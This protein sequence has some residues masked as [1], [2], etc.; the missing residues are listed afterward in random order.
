MTLQLMEEIRTLILNRF[1]FNAKSTTDSV[2]ETGNPN[3]I[4]QD[5]QLL[6]NQL[7]DK[8]LQTPLVLVTFGKLEFSEIV[9]KVWRSPLT[10]EL[11]IVNSR[12][13]PRMRF[14]HL[15][16]LAEHE[17]VVDTCIKLLHNKL[18]ASICE[19]M[20]LKSMEVN[21]DYQ[22]YMATSLKFNTCVQI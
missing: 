1:G 6:C 3:L 2:H 18:F 9:E 13:S 16:H 15:Q 12:V 20:I 8:S 21:Y 4:I 14:N 11:L 7:E 5:V 19:P 22:G 10:V 17:S